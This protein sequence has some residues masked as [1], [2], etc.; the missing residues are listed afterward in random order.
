MVTTTIPQ[1]LT[2]SSHFGTVRNSSC[3]DQSNFQVIADDDDDDG[4]MMMMMVMV[5]SF[6]V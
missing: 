5:I 3:I 4:M 1:T 2:S 6:F